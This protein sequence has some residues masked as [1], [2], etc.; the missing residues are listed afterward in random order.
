MKYINS[1]YVVI[2][3]VRDEAEFLPRVIRSMESQTIR[4]AEWVVVDDGS[5]DDTLAIL[6]QFSSDNVR[7]VTQQNSGLL[8]QSESMWN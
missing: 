5:T 3:P 2:S 4:P 8:K 6:N 1:K 7:V